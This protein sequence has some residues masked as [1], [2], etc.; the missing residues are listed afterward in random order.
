MLK[1]DC[2][3]YGCLFIEAPM[4]TTRTCCKCG[5]ENPK[6]P[7]SQRYLICEECGITIDRDKNAAINC[8]DSY[9]EPLLSQ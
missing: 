5:H 8:Y 3:K 7:L 1:H 2:D 4:K 6:L 9:S